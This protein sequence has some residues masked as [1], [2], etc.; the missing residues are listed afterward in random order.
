MSVCKEIIGWIYSDGT[1]INYPIVQ[2]TNNEYYL[3]RLID[4]TYNQAGS[5]FMDYKNSSDFSDY[6]TI[7]YGHNM[8]NDSMFGTLTSYESQDYYNEHKEMYLYSEN[9]KI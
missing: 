7:I 9:K 3:R 4:G 2:T 6:N 5:I 1:P 8:K